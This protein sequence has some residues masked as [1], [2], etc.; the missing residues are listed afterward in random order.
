MNSD[1][2]NSNFSSDK[3]LTESLNVQSSHSSLEQLTTEVFEDLQAPLTSLSTFAEL[4]TQEYQDNLDDKARA[5]LQEINDSGSKMQ[6]LLTDLQTYA[7][8]GTS[9]QTW[10]TIDLKLILG[11]VLENLQDQ[12][13]R[14]Q[15]EIIIGELPSVLINPQEISQVL[16]HLI[17]N[18]IKFNQ[19]QPRIE[20]NA[21]LEAREWLITVADNGIGIAPE[22]QSEIFQV[23]QRLN[24]VD[25][26]LG[27]GIGLAICH[28]IISH[29]GGKIWLESS[30]GQGSTFYFTIPINVCPP[31]KAIAGRSIF[32]ST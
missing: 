13:N 20:I 21:T 18:G 16:E 1:L 19:N 4:L 8:A 11:K 31:L 26:Y 3:D 9:Q 30:L 17:D 14:K 29:Y 5:Y 10:L 28:K 27:S 2:N 12:I 15:V 24:P 22:Y 23:F 7:L 25:A 6:T 32:L